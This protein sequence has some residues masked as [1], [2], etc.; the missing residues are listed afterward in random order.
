VHHA[1]VAD[2]RLADRPDAGTPRRVVVAGAGLAGLTAAL[3]L[4]DAGWGVVVLEARERVG[5]RVHTARGGIDGV[6]LSS[7]LRAELGGESIDESHTGL[8]GLLRRFG[9]ATERRP[10]STRD[11][12]MHG[13]VRRSGANATLRELMAQRG[14]DVFRDYARA[15]TEID[16]LAEAHAIDPEHPEHARDAA[17]LDRTSFAAWLD[18]LRLGPEADFVVRQANTSLYNSELADLS[19]LFVAQQA[20]AT[21][22]LP[23]DG[24]ETRR[25]AAGNVTLPDA[26]AFELGAAVVRG[27]PVTE[28]RTAADHV[29]VVAG[30]RSY[31]G[32]HLVLALPPPPL[33][34]V[35]FTPALPDRIATAIAGLD[36]G[37]ATKVVN[38]FDRPFWRDGGESGFSLTELTYRVSW[39]AADSYDTPA[40]LLTTYTTADNGRTLAALEPDDRIARVRAELALA[41][42]DSTAH[43]A[44]PA[45]TMAWTTEPYTG[46]GYAYYR[47]G[48]LVPFWA[49][50]RDGTER[51]HFAGEHLDAPAGYMESAVRSGLRAAHR[52]G[53]P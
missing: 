33:R 2:I 3:T 48:R 46:G 26:I 23:L 39:D 32:A 36:L 12:V 43:L 6:T 50:L 44:G 27:A 34:N 8:L 41:F 16:R 45:V 15:Y 5:G 31:T 9:L 51:V 37:G 38:Q 25:V 17:S 4:R 42:P 10:G 13:R 1:T 35:R 21:A 30:D 28:V 20:A 14:G 24:S 29:A 53:S 18:S 11:R 49:A 7:G 52:L 22:G 47:P 19:L 40:G